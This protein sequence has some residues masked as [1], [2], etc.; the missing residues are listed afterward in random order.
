M[1]LDVFGKI[2]CTEGTHPESEVTIPWCQ[3]SDFSLSW[4]F[5]VKS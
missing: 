3:N 4:P 1:S 5:H 2:L